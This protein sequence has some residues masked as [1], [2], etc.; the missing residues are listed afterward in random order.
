M[1]KKNE[2]TSHEVF[3]HFK[4]EQLDK[5]IDSSEVI[6]FKAGEQVFKKGERN[7]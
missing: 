1:L 2:V 4:P 6:K 7:G 5:I 3:K